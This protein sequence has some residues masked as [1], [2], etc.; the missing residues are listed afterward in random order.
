MEHPQFKKLP[1]QHGVYEV[2]E[3]FLLHIQSR[4]ITARRVLDPLHWLTIVT[5]V[6]SNNLGM[7]G[8][9]LSRLT[10]MW[11]ET[12]SS[13]VAIE[14]VHVC[15]IVID[16]FIL[17][18][19]CKASVRFAT[20]MRLRKRDGEP[21]WDKG[22]GKVAPRT[23]RGPRN[24]YKPSKNVDKQIPEMKSSAGTR[25][26]LSLIVLFTV[27]AK[28]ASLLMALWNNRQPRNNRYSPKRIPPFHFHIR[29]IET[30]GR[31]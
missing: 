21:L 11:D 1:A 27:T 8:G 26:D 29:L 6:L 15:G 25:L 31:I 13:R 9:I 30:R 2:R 16:L 22:G 17:W 3:P 4:S 7:L 28:D 20:V 12:I 18:Q 24:P 5:R 19:G 10:G 14:G 23:W